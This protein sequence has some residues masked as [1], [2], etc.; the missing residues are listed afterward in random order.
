M[1]RVITLRRDLAGFLVDATE[2]RAEIRTELNLGYLEAVA[3]SY[4]MNQ[5]G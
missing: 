4:S 5:L 3:I 1:F 2:R